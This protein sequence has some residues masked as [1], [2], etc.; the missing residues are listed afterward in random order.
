[1]PLCAPPAG[2]YVYTWLKEG[3]LKS[4]LAPRKARKVEATRSADDDDEW[5]K[6]T[7]YDNFRKKKAAAAQPKSPKSPSKKLT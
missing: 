2:Y 4:V 6:G 5:V 3:V 1:M 7:P